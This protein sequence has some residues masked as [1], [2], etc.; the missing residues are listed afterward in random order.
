MGIGIGG[1]TTTDSMFYNPSWFS[2]DP[3]NDASQVGKNVFEG[4]VP[5]GF[6]AYL[7]S[8]G[9]PDNSGAFSRWAD[10]QLGKY[11]LG[12]NTYT[13]ADPLNADM[14]KYNA[15]LGG[16]D[17]WYNEFLRQSPVL[18]GEDPGSRGAGP[19]RWIRQ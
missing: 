13:A 17:Q 18:R 15:Q 14:G 5:T 2:G 10:Q 9:I 3:Y 16:F 1:S 7:K 8:M 11:T 6:Y 19:V 12:Y 4:S